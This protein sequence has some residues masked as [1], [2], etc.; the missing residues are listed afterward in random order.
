MSR[1]SDKRQKEFVNPR[2]RLKVD[3]FTWVFVFRA[4]FRLAIAASAIKQFY[5][6]SD[7]VLIG[8]GNA[9]VKL[10]INCFINEERVGHGQEMD[11]GWRLVGEAQRDNDSR[12]GGHAARAKDLLS[13][14]ND[15]LRL[16]ADTANE[17]ER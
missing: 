16:A 4:L 5:L 3:R 17:N 8:G 1:I 13:Q 9:E 7:V 2:K 11:A 6:K 14:A 15:E 10:I 12:L